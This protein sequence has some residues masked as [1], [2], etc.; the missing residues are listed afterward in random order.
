M[1]INAR[2]SFGIRIAR[3]PCHAKARRK[4]DRVLTAAA[5]DLENEFVL[6]NEASEHLE[7]RL[8]VSRRSGR[9]SSCVV[10]VIGAHERRR[11]RMQDCLLFC[12]R[13]MKEPLLR[14]LRKSCFDL[15]LR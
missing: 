11:R 8:A 3:L 15:A 12:D 13:I 9:P 14:F 2:A 7:D 6:R 5:C 1:S 4:K 10:I